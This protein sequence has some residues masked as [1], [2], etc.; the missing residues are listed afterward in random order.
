LEDT[1]AYTIAATISQQIAEASLVAHHA[2][3]YYI[4]QQVRF[5]SID[6]TLSGERF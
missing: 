3:G 6:H 2:L 1:C 5:I 4:R